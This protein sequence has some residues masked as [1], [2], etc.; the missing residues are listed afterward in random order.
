M[1]GSKVEL[2]IFTI[3]IGSFIALIVVLWSVKNEKRRAK[4]PPGGMGWPIVGSTFLIFKPHWPMVIGDFVRHQL[5]KS[6][7]II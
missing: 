7:Y 2:N 4:L 5:S 1:I 6:V 3:L